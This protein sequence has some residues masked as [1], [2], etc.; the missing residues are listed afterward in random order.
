MIFNVSMDQEVML[1]E[2]RRPDNI[3]FE[4]PNRLGQF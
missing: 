2:Y 1:G 4:P 3:D